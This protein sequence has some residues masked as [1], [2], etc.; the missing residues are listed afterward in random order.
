[1]GMLGGYCAPRLAVRKGRAGARLLLCLASCCAL[2]W[3]QAAPAPT[4]AALAGA[5]DDPAGAPLLV[6]PFNNQ[7][8]DQSL[9]WIGESFVEAL[10]DA[11]RADGEVVLSREERTVAFDQAGIPL[12]STLS[13]AT[14]IQVANNVDAAW[15]ITG[16]Y[17]YTPAAAPPP[18][19]GAA[20]PDPASVGAGRF[21]VV[22]NLTD[23]RREHRLRVT[24]PAGRLRDLQ[25]L[26]AQ[27][28]WQ[29]L[30][31]IDPDTALTAAQLEAREQQVALP[32][33]ENYIRGLIATEPA[34][35][36]KFW[37][38]ALR[39]QPGYS[40]AMY[41]TGLWYFNNND[42]KTALLWLPKVHPDDPDYAQAL[43]LA[44][45]AAY[46]L[47][48]YAR[49]AAYDRQLA[50]QL[51]L[52]QVLNNW[53][54]A[55]ARLGDAEAVPL[56]QRALA[57]DPKNPDLAANLGVVECRLGHRSQALRAARLANQWQ[58][59]EDLAA[60]I[61]R[62]A[63]PDAR[64]PDAQAEASVESLATDFPADSFRQ[65]AA[66]IVQFNAAK[67]RQMPSD[68][69]LIFH[70]KQGDDLL[71]KGALEAAENEFRAAL[72]INADSTR[73]HTGLARLY[74]LRQDWPA[75]R[76]QVAVLRAIA[77][78]DPQVRA[79]D[80]AIAKHPH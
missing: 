3:T 74:M 64:C 38:E 17:H 77:P 56:L 65:L 59:D 21:T 26:Q 25:G 12:L 23:M 1:M 49:A 52:P 61:A 54:L 48:D 28:A 47:R 80:A 67:A 5:A 8:P 71:A 15:L 11:L 76:A 35:Q 7:S 30:R 58:P 66:A 57:A 72:A 14:L 45:Q 31:Q 53:A 39:L 24:I 33:Y 55:E 36:L 2:G 63:R 42:F 20:P 78:R 79:L 37:L 27:L 40:R 70:L 13:Q 9:D 18:A 34:A 69:Q 32:A 41:R 73:A 60:F 4:P 29:V 16:A 10:S 75:A 46:Q 6:L 43:F 68:S 22:A 51:P 19:A 62:L 44:G 50:A